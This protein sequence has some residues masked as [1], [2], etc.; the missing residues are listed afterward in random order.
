[1]G[2]ERM[3]ITPE[4]LTWARERA[5]YSLDD[6]AS[7]RELAHI[8]DWESG[9]AAPTY[10]EMEKLACLFEIPTALFFFPSP[11]ELPR[12][13]REF[14]T[15]GEDAFARLVP[16]LQRL[17]QEAEIH[18]RNCARLRSLDWRQERLLVNDLRPTMKDS[19]ETLATEIRGYL[20]LSADRQSGWKT[21][22]KAFEECRSLLFKV[23][24]AIFKSRFRLKGYSGFCLYD[25]KHPVVAVNS[26]VSWQAQL[27]TVFHCLG[28]LLFETSGV[29]GPK[30]DLRPSQSD[31]AARIEGLC[32]KL[33]TGVI[34]PESLLN[35]VQISTEG[36]PDASLLAQNFALDVRQ[37]LRES[38]LISE[39]NCLESN[40]HFAPSHSVSQ[41]KPSI[42]AATRDLV[43]IDYINLAYD[44]YD[45]DEIDE[46]GLA[47]LLYIAPRDIDQLAAEIERA[48][49]RLD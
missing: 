35:A 42:S 38:E 9:A 33:A 18:Q 8:R 39:T 6:S 49:V 24:V 28:Y 41:A 1:M 23:G 16:R 48:G 12:P 13:P 46:D 14:K 32:D 30:R 7:V 17:M 27:F 25:R 43:G 20:D 40:Q 15:L 10:S 29:D 4:V 34:V 36:A 3:P 31:N 37:E 5:G 45:R 21:P 2:V 22:E 26:D 11:P 44:C 19:A 47:D